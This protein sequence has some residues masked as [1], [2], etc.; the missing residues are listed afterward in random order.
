[1]RILLSTC[2]LSIIIT[3]LASTQVRELSP[4]DEE[5][6]EFVQETIREKMRFDP[7]EIEIPTVGE[8]RARLAL[9]GEKGGALPSLAGTDLVVSADFAPESEVHAAINPT[10]EKNIIVSPIR[11]GTGVL[12]CP[13]YYSKDFGKTWKKSSFVNLPPDDRAQV[14]GGGDPVFAFDAN[15]RAYFTWI[16]LYVTANFQ[17]TYAA[18]FWAYSDDGGATWQEAEDN[19]VTIDGGSGQGGLSIFADKQWMAVDKT[20]SEWRNRLYVAY[21]ELGTQ[22]GSSKIVVRR[23]TP[24]SMSFVDESVGVSPLAFS[25]VQFSSIDID[26][27]GFVHVS[28]F[29][30]HV[31]QGW[32]LWHSVSIDGGESFSNPNRISL[33]E[34]GSTRFGAS[35][36]TP[37]PGILDDRLYPSPHI[38][39]DPVGRTTELGGGNIYAVWTALGTT[40]ND[41]SGYNIYCA[42]STDN[43]N[44]WEDPVI[45]HAEDEFSEEIPTAHDQFYSSVSV[46]PDGV[47]AVSW[48]DHREDGSGQ[49]AHYRVACSFD[50]GKTFGASVAVTSETTDFT[51]VGDRNNGFGIGEYTQV[52]T[53]SDYVIPVWSDGRSGDGNMDVY[54]GFVPINKVSLSVDEPERI[55]Q[56]STLL[57]EVEVAPNPITSGQSQLRFNLQKATRLQIELLDLT[58]KQVLDLGSGKVFASGQ[59]QIEIPTASLTSGEYLIS[60][61]T[62]EEVITTGVKV[63][64]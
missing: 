61:K 44:T 10:D 8:I 57:S 62:N 17:S 16:N 23:L 39:I 48:Y 50:G 40:R 45:V 28:F 55:T 13:I 38:A 46:N 32:G 2:C 52:L 11:Q 35:T 9:E 33:I 49:N 37:I 14:L 25:R 43:G 7:E 19:T 42:R 51:T 60:I 36:N 12:L 54:I 24:E 31:S 18:I 6:R 29:G 20:D 63:L 30:R 56:V 47:I 53:T 41:G 21:V 59:H 5:A 34:F 58:G 15:G 1:M 4:E 3:S 64:K 26:A 27:D 22:T